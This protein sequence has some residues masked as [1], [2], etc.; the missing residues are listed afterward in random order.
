MSRKHYDPV[1]SVEPYDSVELAVKAGFKRVISNIQH[2]FREFGFWVVQT[3]QYQ[4]S[5][6]LVHYRYSEPKKGSSGAVRISM[7]VGYTVC[8]YCHT[9]PKSTNSG[10][11]STGDKRSFVK[12][13]EVRPNIPFYLLNPQRQIRRAN[14]ET[15]FPVG[16]T[17]PW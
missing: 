3:V 7:P 13:R 2:E 12:L 11:F 17:V 9:H 6:T 5:T 1:M 15:E 8:A 4:P 16:I 10:N 14:D